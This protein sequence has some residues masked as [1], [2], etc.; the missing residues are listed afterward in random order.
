MRPEAHGNA[1]VEPELEA[2]TAAAAEPRREHAARRSVLGAAFDHAPLV[3]VSAAV[4]VSGSTALAAVWFALCRL[5]Y[6]GFVGLS[7]RAESRSAALSRRHGAEEAWRR[8]RRIA[9]R[10]MFADAVSLGV[11]CVVTRGTFDPPGPTWLAVVV[12][13]VLVVIG[14]GIKSWAAASLDEGTFYWRDF[15]V[16]R[17]HRAVSV[18][19]PYRWLS[20]PMYGVGYAHAYGFALLVGSWPGLVAGACAQ[21]AILTMERLVER[22][23]LRR[24]HRR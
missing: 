9:E 24:R 22:P 16:P 21:V 5:G 18:S 2:E 4:L 12:G 20:N 23:H 1:L 13:L 19:G 15:F 17:E 6:V 7:L 14:I 11:L 3:L 10:I 8:F